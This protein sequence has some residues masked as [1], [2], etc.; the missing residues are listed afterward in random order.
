M[1][2]ERAR[3]LVA[4][5]RQHIESTLAELASEVVADAEVEAQ[6][7]AETDAAD[8][9]VSQMTELG[10]EAD[11]R[12]RLAAVERAEHRIAAGTYGRSI[13]SGATI[14]DERLEA[15]PLAERTVAEQRAVEAVA[16]R[17]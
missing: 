10:L 4:R 5:E 7:T 3:E 16:H 1:D 15:D 17:G 9:V 6:Q 8:E 12:L 2:T 11:L 14:P 13:E